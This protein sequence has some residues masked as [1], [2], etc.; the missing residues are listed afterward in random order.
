MH[1]MLQQDKPDDYVIATGEQRSVKEFVIAAFAELGIELTFTGH[2][3]D[4]IGV[5][6]ALDA[7]LVAG[8]RNGYGPACREPHNDLVQPGR[9]LVKVDPRYF[10]PTEVISLLGDATKAREALGWTPS[11]SFADLVHE[12]VWADLVD[13]QKYDCIRV[14]GLPV[15]DRRSS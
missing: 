14:S 10:R 9:V 3:L 8:A 1:L 11:A 4:E 6:N 13:A 5:V 15:T 2:G 7:S 12:M